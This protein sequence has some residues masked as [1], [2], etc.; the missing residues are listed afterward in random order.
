VPPAPAFLYLNCNYSEGE[1]R[2]KQ[3]NIETMMINLDKISRQKYI[4][5]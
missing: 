1:L 5:K 2:E 4:D 3:K